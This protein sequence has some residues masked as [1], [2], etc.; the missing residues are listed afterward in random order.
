MTLGS[1]CQRPLHCGIF[2]VFL[3]RDVKIY[4]FVDLRLNL[5]EFIA[6]T[7]VQLRGSTQTQLF[8]Y[9]FIYFYSLVNNPVSNILACSNYG[10]SIKLCHLIGKGFPPPLPCEGW[11]P[12]E[13]QID[14]TNKKTLSDSKRR[15]RLL[16]SGPVVA[17][18]DRF[19][20]C[21]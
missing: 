16:L 12:K 15:E 2:G 6:L 8:F 21:V 19:E 1:G 3:I 10:T 13:R 5:I 9:F 4:L 18:V 11:T 17:R 20:G 7:C 14:K